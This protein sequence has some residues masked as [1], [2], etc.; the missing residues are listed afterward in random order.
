[1]ECFTTQL[2]DDTVNKTK[3][4]NKKHLKEFVFGELKKELL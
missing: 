3:S 1:M 2:I 4:K